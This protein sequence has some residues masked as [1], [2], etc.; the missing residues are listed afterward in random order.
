MTSLIIIN[1]TGAILLTDI[2][3]P[4]GNYALITPPMGLQ[5]SGY[6]SLPESVLFYTGW[7]DSPTFQTVEFIPAWGD[8][9]QIESAMAGLLQV[10]VFMVT[11]APMLV[12][13]VNA[14]TGEPTAGWVQAGS[15][16]LCQGPATWGDSSAIYDPARPPKVIEIRLDDCSKAKPPQVGGGARAGASL[17]A[18]G[19]TGDS[20]DSLLAGVWPGGHL[21]GPGLAVLPLSMA[22]LFLPYMYYL[23]K[24]FLRMLTQS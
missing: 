20:G 9:W 14:I 24:C 19:T 5:L 13:S 21:S 11:P 3:A 7:V 1:L 4:I 8:T 23:S 6:G 17:P 18:T 12:Y 10:R 2:R 15:L 16:V 22:S